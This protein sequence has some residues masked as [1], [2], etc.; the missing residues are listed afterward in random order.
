MDLGCGTGS[1]LLVRLGHRRQIKPPGLLA[2]YV[3][4]CS[5]FRIFE[6]TLRV[7][8]SEHILGLRLNFFVAGLFCV[9]GLAWF[10]AIQRGW[11]PRLRRRRISPPSRTRKRS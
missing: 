9:A 11:N 6:E 2:L 3:A 1:Q 8:Y 5:G 10:A 7:D 4:A